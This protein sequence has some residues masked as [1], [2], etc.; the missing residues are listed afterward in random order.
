MIRTSCCQSE[1]ILQDA[2][3]DPNTSEVVNTFDNFICDNTDCDNHGA[4]CWAED[5]KAK[6]AK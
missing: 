2:Y 4:E 1:A 6:E 5:D 3:V